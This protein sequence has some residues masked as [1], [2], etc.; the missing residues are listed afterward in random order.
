MYLIDFCH[1]IVPFI[2]FCQE[3]ED[4]STPLFVLDKITWTGAA[5]GCVWRQKPL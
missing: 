1:P 3:F 5:Q 2:E 4:T